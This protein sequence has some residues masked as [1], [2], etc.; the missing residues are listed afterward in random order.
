[1][2]S[3]VLLAQ[4]KVSLDELGEDPTKPITYSKTRWVGIYYSTARYIKHFDALFVMGK[5]GM[6]NDYH[7]DSK[8]AP[9]EKVHAKDHLIACQSILQTFAIGVATLEGEKYPT[10]TLVPHW[11]NR[12]RKLLQSNTEDH[13]ASDF[14]AKLSERLEFYFPNFFEETNLALISAALHVRFT[15]LKWCSP[16]V[17]NQVWEDAVEQAFSLFG[18]DDED[19]PSVE[20]VRA[21][22]VDARRRLLKE[23][24]AIKEKRA[25]M[26]KES[27]PWPDPLEWWS[28]RIK[29]FP[30][31]ELVVKLFLGAP[32][33]EA[34]CERFFKNSS[35][36]EVGRTN[37]SPQTLSMQT[38]VRSQLKVPSDLKAVVTQVCSLFKDQPAANSSKPHPPII[39]ADK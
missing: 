7:L 6:F 8:F 4:L 28:G 31:L 15:P 29:S 17:A 24:N 9:W 25:S 23:H 34:A 2:K 39:I 37:I 36:A 11:L 27:A 33:T 26:G 10:L 35:F 18:E 19:R 22:F 32:A 13:I 30:H 20:T 3:S 14:Q 38:L 1:M 12:F 16:N 5:E 21:T